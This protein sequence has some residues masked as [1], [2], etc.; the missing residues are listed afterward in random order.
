MIIAKCECNYLNIHKCHRPFVKHGCNSAH[1]GLGPDPPPNKTN[2]FHTT[3]IPNTKLGTIQ[4]DPQQYKNAVTVFALNY[5]AEDNE[6]W[7]CMAL[8]AP[9]RIF[10]SLTHNPEPMTIIWDS[11]ASAS[12]TP[13]KQAFVD[14]LKKVPAS[15]KLIGLAKNL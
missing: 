14:G 10:S 11:G 7:L 1:G 9:L 8:Q 2:T 6:T 13:N 3:Q 5:M 4:H 15:I 12:I